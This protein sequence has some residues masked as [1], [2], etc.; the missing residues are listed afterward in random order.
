[1]SAERQGS[2][3]SPDGRRRDDREAGDAAVRWALEVRAADEVLGGLDAEVRRLRLRRLR[4]AGWGGVATFTLLG[5]LAW[6]RFPPAGTAPGTSPGKVEASVSR[7]S[8]AAQPAANLVVSHPSRRVLDDG[9][10][11]E[12]KPGAEIAVAFSAGERRVTLVR[13]EAHFEVSKNAARPFVVVA[14]DL[15]AR[16]VGTAFAVQID[17]SSVE[18]LVT[19]G[20]VAVARRA[21]AESAA[22]ATAPAEV[23][24]R[25]VAVA[26]T[27]ARESALLVA[28][29][30]LVISRVAPGTVPGEVER[31]SE[32]QV[33]DRLAWRA[34]LLEFASAP[35]ADV[36][37][38]F[39]EI[40]RVRIVLANASLREIQ[41]SGSMRA[42][43]TDALVKLLELE[44]GVR[45]E[46]EGETVVLHAR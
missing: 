2:N 30:R 11:V 42:N 32:R 4:R 43:R 41:V 7:G 35:L 1:M 15:E 28:H 22:A 9:S 3:M 10:R 6:V 17:P 5:A 27:S 29:E 46:R 36:V 44:F 24:A 20:K 39:N 31:L 38:K 19:E 37:A 40:G 23:G 14:G 45:A 21:K 33:D 13:G 26:A 25:P 8:V 18:V 16:A 34:A 12:L